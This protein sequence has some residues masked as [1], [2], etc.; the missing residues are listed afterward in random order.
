[1]AHTDNPLVN[2]LHPLIDHGIR[3]CELV[4]GGVKLLEQIEARVKLF[5]R[6]VIIL[7]I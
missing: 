1:M 5:W 2:V 6:F 7:W 3:E 4:E